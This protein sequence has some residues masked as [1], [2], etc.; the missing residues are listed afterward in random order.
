M[1]EVKF[2][3]DIF[4]MVVPAVDDAFK[5]AV[6]QDAPE[7]ESPKRIWRQALGS[8]TWPWVNLR[9]DWEWNKG[10]QAPEY[11]RVWP[12]MAQQ[13]YRDLTDLIENGDHD[14]VDD[15]LLKM[16]DGSKKTGRTPVGVE[17][18]GLTIYA[19]E[20]EKKDSVEYTVYMA[21]KVHWK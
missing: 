4:K 5:S 1:T 17:I 16:M 6:P 8:F 18:G 20:K 14:K 9:L 15:P 11:K 19:E 21:V 2:D 13:V 7:G 3:E 12:L 10:S